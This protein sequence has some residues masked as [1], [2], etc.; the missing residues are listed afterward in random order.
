MSFSNSE[1]LLTFLGF[2]TMEDIELIIDE[3][4]E[5][6]GVHAVSVV[7][8]PATEESFIALSKE[9]VLLKEVDKKRNILMGGALIPDKRILRRD[10]DGNEYNVYFS[11]ETVLRA[12]ELFLINANQSNTTLEHKDKLEGLTVVESWIVGKNDKSKDYGLDL[13]EGS[14]AI[15]MKATPEIYSKAMSGEV[16]GFSIEGFFADSMEAK[17]Q[18]EDKIKQ[19]KNLLKIK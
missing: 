1:T 15:S 4:D 6:N 16:T 12:S 3:S 17:M 14:W 7:E 13:P 2:N 11:K 9:K 19:L 18:S 5:Q 8:S 10:K